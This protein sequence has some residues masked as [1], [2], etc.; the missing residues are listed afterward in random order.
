LERDPELTV[1]MG[2]SEP[3]IGML[4]AADVAYVPMNSAPEVRGLALSSDKI[5]LIRAQNQ[6]ALL[7]AV[8][9]LIQRQHGE[10][11]D[12]SHIAGVR[13]PVHLIDR[14]LDLAG[15]SARLQWFQVTRAR[16]SEG[17]LEGWKLDW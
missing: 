11:I 6:R 16:L 1:A 12:R 8:V 7:K 5:H 3:D 15:Q 10:K 13:P 17:R 9:D 4:Q 14:I 2:D